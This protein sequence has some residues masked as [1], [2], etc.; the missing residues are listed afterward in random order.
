MR[1]V[2]GDVDKS[3][4][5]KVKKSHE[6]LISEDKKIFGGGNL[7]TAT[8]TAT[9]PGQVEGAHIVVECAAVKVD[10]PAVAIGLP[11]AG[12]TFQDSD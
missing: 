10:A 3:G 8:A 5:G 1:G 7:F 11:I 4:T 2:P 6:Q 9:I 12:M